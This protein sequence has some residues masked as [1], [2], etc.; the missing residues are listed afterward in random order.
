M[1][2]QYTITGIMVPYQFFIK[3][4][5]IPL[6]MRHVAWYQR[7]V[8]NLNSRL[9]KFSTTFP[10]TFLCHAKCDHMPMLCFKHKDCILCKSQL[11][12][13]PIIIINI[14]IE[15]FQLYDLLETVANWQVSSGSKFISGL[16]KT[17]IYVS[18]P[19]KQIF[20]V[21]CTVSNR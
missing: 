20:S 6:R 9:S 17:K 2:H 19:Y 21:F 15:R 11:F 5:F 4:H 8:Y 13:P 1:F 10:S 14:N 18:M 3:C 7:L 12:S 16:H